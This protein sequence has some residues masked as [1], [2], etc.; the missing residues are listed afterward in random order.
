MAAISAASASVANVN[1]SRTR[2][3]RLRFTMATL[4]APS[5]PADTGDRYVV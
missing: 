2:A 5:T 3:V 4:M 1:A